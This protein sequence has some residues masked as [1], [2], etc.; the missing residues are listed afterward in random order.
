M[1]ASLR[2]LWL[3]S[4]GRCA[5]LLACHHGLVPYS[6]QAAQGGARVGELCIKLGR[7]VQSL[8]D[9]L[10]RGGGY[11]PRVSA[12]TPRTRRSRQNVGSILGTMNCPSPLAS[13]LFAGASP[14]PARKR[15]V[16]LTGLPAIDE[17]L[18]T[19]WHDWEARPKNALQSLLWESVCHLRTL[20]RSCEAT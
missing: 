13:V 6:Q 7:V 20:S 18:R 14:S 5:S 8:G 19:I 12:R 17:R 9:G 16:V 3:A 1:P 11:R 10:A 2:G 4:S 15:Q